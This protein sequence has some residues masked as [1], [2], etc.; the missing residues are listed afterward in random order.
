MESPRRHTK[1]FIKIGVTVSEEFINKHRHRR[2][3]YTKISLKFRSKLF[4]L[5]ELAAAQNADSKSKNVIFD[6]VI[7]LQSAGFNVKHSKINHNIYNLRNQ[8][9]KQF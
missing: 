2:N 9:N 6:T 8:F 4:K 3:I 5:H 7:I 1:K